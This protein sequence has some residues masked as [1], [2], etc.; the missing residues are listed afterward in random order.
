MKSFYEFLRFLEGY[1]DIDPEEETERARRLNLT[2]R[3]PLP[4]DKNI[5]ASLRDLTRGFH[6]N[7]IIGRMLT[8]WTVSLESIAPFR[9]DLAKYN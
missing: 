6:L 7:T 2:A 4:K 1:K 9:W 3:L 5:F 8:P